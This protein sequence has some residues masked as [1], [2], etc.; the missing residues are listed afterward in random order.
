MTGFQLEDVLPLT[1]LQA[2][3]LFH[4]LYDAE[5]VD[6]YTSQFVLALEGE[7]DPAALRAALGALLR[8]H[9][10]LRVGFLHEDLDQPVQAVAAE[11]PVPLHVADLTAAA[12]GAEAA[13]G[14]GAAVEERLRE[15]LAADRVRRFDL[16][17]PPL[18][19][20]A[21]LRTGPAR[22]RLVITSH[23]ILLDGWSVPLL[24]R[25]LFE[26]YGS[27]GDAAG[28]PRVA[29]YRSY[30]AWLAGQDRGA[31][32][33]AWRGALAGVEAPTLL[34]GRAAARAAHAGELPE[35]LVLELDEAA[36]ERLRATARAHRLTLNTLVQ[37]AWGLLLAGLTGRSDVLF[38]TTVSGRP[39]E[40]PGVES[41]IGL[42]INTVPVR[43]AVRPGE[44]LAA[45]LAR[46][47][48][49]QGALLGSQHV[50]LTDIG[51][52][53]GLDTLFDTLLVF[54]NY[55]LDQEGLRAA[56][57]ALPGLAVTGMAGSDAAHYPL[58]LTVAPGRTLR[59]TFAFRPSVLERPWAERTVDRLR[60]LLELLGAGLA[61]RA[62]AVPVLL[63]GERE[64]LLARGAGA[65]LPTGVA[66]TDLAAAVARWAAERPEAP[67]VAG[68]VEPLT[69]RRL[70]E[71]SDRLAG[72]LTGL[73]A[74]PRRAWACCWAARPRRSP[75]RWGC[76]GRA[77]R[78][79]RWTRA[80]RPS[81][82]PRSPRR[83]PPGCWW[84]TPRTP[85]TRGC[86]RWGP[87]CGC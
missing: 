69:Y 43:L 71:L 87:G 41:M 45:L 47:Q 60:G 34:A 55:P 28:L 17:S 18:M 62:D 58:T 63:A 85:G 76:C 7:V 56:G 46:L 32:L 64:E 53:T 68:A 82:W 52:T 70:V 61:G 20:F 49:E 33:D 66:G 15:F 38:G 75:R 13:A 23:H 31:A 44:G 74:A 14:D 29:P 8:R 37:G 2:G 84:W 36:T 79:C 80:G 22:Y 57:R 86:G 54:E 16:A 59:I 51:A 19:R 83:R 11:V 42:F 73:G 77:R 40:L 3:M 10:N 21:L 12:D 78:T 1:P 24:L 50:G 30:L 67:A 39:P 9:A 25:E 48:D 4:A 35:T 26:L 65:A 5:A 6:V 72:A 27:G 81:G